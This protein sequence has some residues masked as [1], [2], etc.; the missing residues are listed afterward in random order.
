MPFSGGKCRAAASRPPAKSPARCR[1]ISPRPKFQVDCVRAE[2]QRVGQALGQLPGELDDELLADGIRA[3]NRVRRLLAALRQTVYAAPAAPLPALEMLVAEML[4]IHFCSDREETIAVLEELLAE[5]QGARAAKP[6][7]RR[8]GG[9]AD[10]LGESGGGFA[11]DEPAGRMWRADVRDRLHVCARA[12]FDSRRFAAAGSAGPHGTGRP[13]GRD[14]PRIGPRAS[15]ANAGQRRRSR[16]G[17]AHSR[18]QPLRARGGNHP[19]T[20]AR[21]ELGIP[22][23]E[24]EIPPLCDAMLPTLR[25]RLEALVEAARAR[26]PK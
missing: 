19:R 10:F 5:A 26:R 4:A 8:R 2:L 1:E 16:G 13:H 17:L 11:G 3:A 20:G 18:R 15:F 23:I 9:G 7:C 24:L 12:G 25:S 22:A 21:R 14:R 6:I